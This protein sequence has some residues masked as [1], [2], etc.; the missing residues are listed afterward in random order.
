MSRKWKIICS[1]YLL[2]CVA[3]GTKETYSMIKQAI[4][5]L[6]TFIINNI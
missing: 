1:I 4:I 6:C 5:D 2:W 3:L